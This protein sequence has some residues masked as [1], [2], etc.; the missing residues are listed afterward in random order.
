MTSHHLEPVVVL[1]ETMGP[2]NI[3]SVAR[4]AAAFG[5]TGFRLVS[6]QCEMDEET[7]K[8]ACY[9]KRLFDNITVYDELSEALEDVSFAVALS[10]RDGKSRHKHYTLPQI[11]E[12]VL[13]NQGPNGRIAYVFGNEESGLANKHLAC[14][15]VS[16]EIPVVAED[17][18]LNLAHAVTTTLYE[19]IGRRNSQPR[20][21]DPKNHHEELAEPEILKNLLRQASETLERVGYPRHR[22]SLEEEVVKLERIAARSKLQNWEVKLLLGMLKQL[23]YRLDHPQ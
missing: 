16:A 9:G 3:G 11:V 23:N 10:R 21:T 1:V 18:S 19:V 12:D 5:L 15:H 20:S 14:C 22:S 4:S 13:P 8:W 7:K 6:P 17:G 2:A